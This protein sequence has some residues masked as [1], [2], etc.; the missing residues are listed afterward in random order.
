MMFISCFLQTWFE[1]QRI[2]YPEH[3]KEPVNLS[4]GTNGG[5][6]PTSQ[7]QDIHLVPTPACCS[8]S[9]KLCCNEQMSLPPPLESQGFVPLDSVRVFGS[10]GPG[11]TTLR[12]TGAM[13]EGQNPDAPLTYMSHSPE[14]PIIEQGFSGTQAPFCSQPDAEHEK[15]QPEDPDYIDI[16]Y[17]MQ[18]WDKGRLELIA[19]WEPQKET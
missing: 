15:Q 6:H 8:P 18:W 7:S 16:S 9:S 14:Q 1:K 5:P 3:R 17:V 12:A 10:V 2:L 11:A 4:D 19:K 13:Q